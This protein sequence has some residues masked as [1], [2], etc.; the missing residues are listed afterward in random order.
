MPGKLTTKTRV[1]VT[2]D[3]D[4][5]RRCQHL[6]K[7]HGFN[8]SNYLEQALLTALELV[9]R[10]E[11]VHSSTGSLEAVVSD[12]DRSAK[13][14]YRDAISQLRSSLLSPSSGDS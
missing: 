1:T 5:W 14:A 6:K 7:L 13:Y 9:D 12:F 3:S 11:Q 2:I 8:W 4:V 10:A